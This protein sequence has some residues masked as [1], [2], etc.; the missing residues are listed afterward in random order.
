MAVPSWLTRLIRRFSRSTKVPARGS[1]AVRR[2]GSNGMTLMAATTRS[3]CCGIRGANSVAWFPLRP[4]HLPGTCPGNLSQPAGSR[5]GGWRSREPRRGEAPLAAGRSRAPQS[6]RSRAPAHAWLRASHAWCRSH[7]RARSRPACPHHYR[8]LPA[9]RRP[10]SSP[11]ALPA[12]PPSAAPPSARKPPVGPWSLHFRPNGFWP[13]QIRVLVGVWR[14][15][16]ATRALTRRPRPRAGSYQE[17]GRDR[18]PAGQ[19]PSL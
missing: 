17:D 7:R 16:R 4:P 18:E 11:T 14:R 8:A 9:Q 13:G 1:S 5:C 19:R 3:A 2:N 6:A 12:L 15:V 10:A